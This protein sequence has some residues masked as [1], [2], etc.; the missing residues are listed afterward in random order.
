M[1]LENRS[2]VRRV[3]IPVA[4]VAATMMA[5]HAAPSAQGRRGGGGDANAGAPIATNTIQLNPPAYY[6]KLVTVTAG[7]ERILSKTTFL[8]DQR[9]A[10]S[11]TEIQPV[12]KPI[13]VIAPYLT[14]GVVQKSY[15]MIRGE[16]IKFDPAAITRSA[17]GYTLDLDPEVAAS[18]AGQPV[19]VANSVIDST[20]TELGRKPLPPPRPEDVSLTALMKTINPAFTALR[21]AADASQAAVVA[22]NVAKLKPAL[23]QTESIWDGLGA[24]PAA[25][26][27][28]QARAHAASIETAAAAGNWEAVKTSASALNQMCQNCHG[29]YRERLEDGTF[30][31]KQGSF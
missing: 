10:V 22:E 5:M 6:G 29:V 13:L 9:K 19:L 31:M 7:V 27:A 21:T 24:S 26:M 8:V 14:T 1:T 25:E 2:R 30:R 3:G 23:T 17:A 12:G 15:L 16:I 28:R 11:A 18:Y 4:V 20:F